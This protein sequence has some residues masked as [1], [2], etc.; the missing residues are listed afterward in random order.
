[1]NCIKIAED[2]VKSHR[3]KLGAVPQV[4]PVFYKGLQMSV[5]EAWAVVRAFEQK[6]GSY[7]EWDGNTDN[8]AEVTKTVF[9]GISGAA[10]TTG[11]G[12]KAF[13]LTAIAGDLVGG[14]GKGISNLGETISGG[15][16]E[17]N[18]RRHLPLIA[19]LEKQ[20]A[21]LEKAINEVKS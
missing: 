6:K 2:T 14:L 12:L 15:I 5:D 20:I 3:D 18:E 21:I 9:D 4:L 8:A 11:Q 13:P 16:R 7:L 10:D 17:I 19:E 1:M